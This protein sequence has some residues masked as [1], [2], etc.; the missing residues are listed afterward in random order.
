MSDP[1]W[2][3]DLW[4][5]SLA[6]LLDPWATSLVHLLHCLTVSNYQEPR[7]GNF[8][9]LVWMWQ[10][11]LGNIHTFPFHRITL[12]GH[13]DICHWLFISLVHI[14]C[15][16]LPIFSFYLYFPF[17]F[18]ELSRRNSLL[19]LWLPHSNFLPCYLIHLSNGSIEQNHGCGVFPCSRCPS[20]WRVWVA[21]LP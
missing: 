2:I 4:A 18:L 8:N 9:L 21:L 11:L 14:T 5:T 20:L 1:N 6:H 13:D 10:R 17:F 12:S 16:L 7:S 19:S 3:L 15:P